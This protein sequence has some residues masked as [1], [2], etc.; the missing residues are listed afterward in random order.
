M[1]IDW[2]RSRDVYSLGFLEGRY[3]EIT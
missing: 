2:E 3:Q 1:E